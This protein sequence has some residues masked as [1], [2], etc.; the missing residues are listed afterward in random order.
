MVNL[1]CLFWLL[2]ALY[3]LVVF[4]AAIITFGAYHQNG[5]AWLWFTLVSVGVA[6]IWIP[7]YWCVY[8]KK[9]KNSSTQENSKQNGK[10]KRTQRQEAAVNEFLTLQQ[11]AKNDPER[12]QTELDKC[13]QETLRTKFLHDKERGNVT[14][15]EQ[16]LIEN[17]D[18]VELASKL[19]EARRSIAIDVKNV[20]ACDSLPDNNSCTKQ[21]VTACGKA[22]KEIAPTA[23]DQF[24]QLR[25]NG[26]T[27]NVIG[28]CKGAIF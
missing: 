11:E 26:T 24:E 4:V 27:E 10:T 17:P 14:V 1:W 19:Q 16:M 8:V 28:F 21:L 13:R 22:I 18:D 9:S 20:A 2:L 25:D 23:F 3:L 7:L 5:L 6:L 12:C 15:L